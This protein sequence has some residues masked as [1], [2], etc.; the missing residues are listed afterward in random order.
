[1]QYT[2]V[3][4]L[5]E[6]RDPL[7]L[8]AFAGWN[9]AAEAAT[10]SLRVL[11]DKWDARRFAD[12]DAEEFY[13]FTSTRPIVRVGADFQRQLEWPANAYYYHRDPSLPRDL[14]ILVG[15]EPHLKWKAFTGEVIDLARQC[16]VSMVVTLG[17]MLADTPHTRP[18][19]LIGFATD[20]ALIA[21]LRD[22]NIGPTRYQGPTGILGAI[23]DACLREELPAI[24]LW[25][26]VPH[27]LGVTQNPK[28]ASALLHSVDSL[29]G[30]GIDLEDLDEAVKR[31]E[32]QVNTVIAR[33]PEAAAYV[34]ELERR[35]DAALGGEQP[36]GEEGEQ[37]EFPSSEALIH[38]L[39]EFLR[40]RRGE[41]GGSD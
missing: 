27:Y 18:V 36:A 38:D 26:S 31:F 24:S 22:M 20:A 29:F 13:D 3:E 11:I 40:R 37:V 33:N 5:P 32:E 14:V 17:A 35:V 2:R 8:V 10:A 12:I 4:E 7:L 34:R 1:M 30:L 19:P 23:H 25:A 6:L 28:V 16:G 41:N 39:E 9:D 15:N 21:R